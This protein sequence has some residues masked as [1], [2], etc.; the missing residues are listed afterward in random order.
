VT[1]AKKAAV[2]Q[3]AKFYATTEIKGVGVRRVAKTLKGLGKNGYRPE[4]EKA[5]L[6]RASAVIAS[7]KPAK[8]EVKK[9]RRINGK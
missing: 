7:Q 3:P 1:V 9:G 5:A 2:Y 4:L 8:K 6:A